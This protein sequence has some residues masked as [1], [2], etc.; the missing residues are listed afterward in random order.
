MKLSL[1]FFFNNKNIHIRNN[2]N[3][4]CV[5]L[6]VDLTITN[7]IKIIYFNETYDFRDVHNM[8]GYFM[9]KS[10]FEA[11]KKRL[12]NKRP[13]ILTR[14]FYIGSH[15]YAAVWTGDNIATY[16]D[17]QLSIQMLINSALCGFSFIGAD[18]GGFSKNT[19]HILMRRWFQ[20]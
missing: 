20:V 5:F 7:E 17:L 11:L 13:F 4:P 10:S 6:R 15:R 16:H 2:L 1:L 19:D 8:Y 3:K 14:S 18:V 12:V 9:H